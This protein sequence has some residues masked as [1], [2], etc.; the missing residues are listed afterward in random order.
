LLVAEVA[1]QP[2]AIGHT[3]RDFVD[4]ER[5]GRH[6][7]TEIYYPADTPG[8]DVPVAGPP[9][10]RFP[11]LSFGHGYLMEWT[12]YENVWTPLVETGYVMALPRT[13]GNLFPDHE[14]LAID[15]VFVIE[16]LQLAGQQ[17]SSIFFDRIAAT[18]GV[19]GH[20]M[21]GGASLLAAALG[22]QIDV[23]ANLAAA[24]TNPSAIAAAATITQPAL[25]FSGSNDCVTPPPDH[26]I[27]MYDA[28]ES[29][30]K[31]WIG[32]DGGSHCQFAQPNFL[33]ELGEAA[34]T[35]PAIPRAE[36]HALVT[37][38]VSPWLDAF[39]K[40][41]ASAWTTFLDLLVQG[42]GITTMHDCEVT[43][44]GGH[45]DGATAAAGGPT[46]GPNRPNP[47]NPV[48][49]ID[50]GLHHRGPV[51]IVIVSPEGRRVRHLLA[52]VV[53]A[54][55]HRVTWRGV[56]DDGRPVASGVY[57]CRLQTAHEVRTHKLV[58]A[59]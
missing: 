46:L 6:V 2:Y 23:V 20:S 45:E 8:E 17:P 11:L 54:G 3:S 40:A 1:A 30:C 29:S 26:Q 57:F 28:L 25:L 15:L 22:A 35:P 5:G 13:E 16:Q 24:E 10:T 37:Q 32:I 47:F 53:A 41:D 56:D 55:R 39:L 49:T 21:G 36:Q 34:C 44:V 58:L 52:D 48:T 18:A 50:Y 7:P 33:C 31:T 42:V 27:P 9:G 38:F 14:Q 19:M 51:S 59:R 43:A 12:A 4:P